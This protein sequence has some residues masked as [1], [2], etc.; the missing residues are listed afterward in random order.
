MTTETAIEIVLNDK[1]GMTLSDAKRHVKNGCTIYE[2]MDFYNHF[3]E[4]MIDWS[5]DKDEMAAYLHMILFERDPVADWGIA[6]YEG[7]TYFIAYVL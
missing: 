1:D 3:Q 6:E 7:K 4:Y 2:K 5:C